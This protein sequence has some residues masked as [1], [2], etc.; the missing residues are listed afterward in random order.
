MHN[1]FI[2]Q[3]LMLMFLIASGPFGCLVA[4]QDGVSSALA[5]GSDRQ[6]QQN[7]PSCIAIIIVI[8]HN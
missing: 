7:V 3:M 4:Q 6:R 5:P 8:K 2:G 1:H